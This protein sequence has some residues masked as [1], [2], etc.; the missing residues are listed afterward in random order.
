[1]NTSKKGND[2]EQ[3]VFAQIKEEISEDRFFVNKKHCKLFKKKGYFSKDRE[4]NRVF[5]I[6]IEVF[7]P[8]HKTFSF[9]ILIECKNYNHPVPV[10]D[11]EEFHGKIQQVAGVNV[12]GIVISTNS[13]QDGA[14][15]FAKS[16]GM[17]LARYFDRS[18]LNWI[19]DRSPSSLLSTNPTFNKWNTASQGLFIESFESRFYDFHCYSGE[20]FT[21]ALNLFFSNLTKVNTSEECI[22]SLAYIE[23]PLTPETWLVEYIDKSEIS[24][25]CDS[26]LNKISYSQ[27]EVPLGQICEYLSK[28]NGLKVKYKKNERNNNVLGQITFK[29]LEIII[30]AKS[31]KKAYSE[32][33]TLAHEL[34]HY[35]LMHSK[36]MA[37]EHCQET[38]IDLDN[39]LDIGIK[40]IMRMEWQANAFA[41]CLLLPQKPFVTDFIDMATAMELRNKGFGVLYL[42]NQPCNLNHYYKITDF[43]KQ[44]YNVS[45]S[46]I[47]IRLKKLGLLKEIETIKKI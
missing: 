28:E 7:L 23:N 2:L 13:F 11:I 31:G 24:Q 46:V 1:M 40:D 8:G 18:E 17:G 34:G 32:R 37:G 39:P 27:G 30:Y 47:K 10:D 22:E 6:S 29:P 25:Q 3:K 21:N 41:S 38:N 4:K 44:K 9:L 16:K 36:Y 5:D 45:R 26:I 12:K 19:L 42:D 15:K 14:F 20:Q 35:F 43:L 33:F